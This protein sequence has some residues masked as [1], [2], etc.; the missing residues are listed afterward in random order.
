M[1]RSILAL[2]MLCFAALIQAQEESTPLW[3][4]KRNTGEYGSY[5]GA[6]LSPDGSKVFTWREGESFLLDGDTGEE[7][8]AIKTNFIGVDPDR[9]K[10]SPDSTRIL[11]GSGIIEAGSGAWVKEWSGGIAGTWN[12]DG[13]H[14]LNGQNPPIGVYDGQTG[15]L[16]RELEGHYGV[17][18]SDG[19]HIA[20]RSMNDVFVYS[21]NGEELMS[22]TVNG[23]DIATISISPDNQK[24]AVTFSSAIPEVIYILNAENGAELGQIITE[25]VENSGF[26]GDCSMT[27][28][29][30]LQ[31]SWSPDSTH[32]V[33]WNDYTMQ[34]WN[35]LKREKVFEF[36]SSTTPV[37]N[38]DGSR[39][40]T[41]EGIFDT[42]TGER[43]IAPGGYGWNS[44]ETLMFSYDSMFGAWV[45]DLATRE[46]ILGVD[47]AAY[48]S[49]F[50][51][52][53]IV[54]LPTWSD[55]RLLAWDNNGQW[56]SV[57]G[58]A[59]V[60]VLDDGL[61][62][63][64]EPS[65]NAEVLEKMPDGTVV[66]IIAGPQAADGFIWWQVRT[67]GGNEGW[68]VEQADNLTTLQNTY[69]AVEQP[70]PPVIF[71]LWQFERPQ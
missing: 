71:K 64:V 59:T 29:G 33:V 42:T 11:T 53:P 30:I 5:Y 58:Q 13:T 15:E 40:M 22:T 36:S 50:C 39:L 45:T 20:T 32:L 44:D 9:P 69:D 4:V 3:T 23:P 27:E 51:G 70:D 68:S 1:K 38:K 21:A 16:V 19:T 18:S 37:W 49:R 6:V 46:I 43:I 55:T 35:A 52:F 65:I 2:L 62:L 67:E 26:Q 54:I 63:R 12:K 61:S 25:P 28:P 7:L 56:I 34:L 57:G 17:W 31:T 10:W 66:E 41:V 8:W 48:D 60:N 47:H 24:L 14:I